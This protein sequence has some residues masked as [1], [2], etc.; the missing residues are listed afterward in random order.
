MPKI[1]LHKKAEKSL[2]RL[3]MQTIRKVHEFI[4]ELETNPVPWKTWDIRK[5]K[6]EKD[7]YRVRLDKYRLIYMVNWKEK[8][9]VI[10]KIEPRKKAY[11]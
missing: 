2:Y 9:I 5:I 11:I 6:G 4:T 1:Y 3:P 7:T 10:L 8:E